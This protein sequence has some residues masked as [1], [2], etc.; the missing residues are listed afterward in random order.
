VRVFLKYLKD[1]GRLLWF[2]P[3][4]TPTSAS[5][6]CKSSPPV[7]PLFLSFSCRRTPIELRYRQSFMSLRIATPMFF[8]LQV[9]ATIFLRTPSTLVKS[10]RVDSKSSPPFLEYLQVPEDRLIV[11]FSLASPPDCHLPSF[12]LPSPWVH[13]S[14]S[15]IDINDS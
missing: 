1:G 3:S 15:S 7:F 11:L 5:L 6:L 12:R 13:Y 4:L 8:P 10:C 9:P 14:L 2:F